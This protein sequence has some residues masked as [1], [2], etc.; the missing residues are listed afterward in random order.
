M[1]LRETGWG[2]MDWINLLE[3]VEGSCEHGGETSLYV[4]FGDFSD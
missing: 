1:Y 3:P 4:N 2:G